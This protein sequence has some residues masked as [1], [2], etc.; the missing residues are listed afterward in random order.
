MSCYVLSRRRV[1][2]ISGGI[3]EL[4]SIRWEIL[5]CLIVM[6]IIC[7]FCVW[8][9]VKSTGKV[10]F[11]E[12]DILCLYKCVDGVTLKSLFLS[13]VVYFSATFPYVMLLILLVRGLSLPGA[14][15]GVQFYLMPDI[16]KIA[17]AQVVHASRWRVSHSRLLGSTHSHSV[18]TGLDGGCGPNF[19]LIQCGCW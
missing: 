9:G 18:S 15:E 2:S 8:K 5:L 6:W 1:L 14:L 7:Y 4:N 3:E 16:K 19:L 10:F 11:W 12:L 17:N 13:Q